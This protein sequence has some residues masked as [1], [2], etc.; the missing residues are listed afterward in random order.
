MG[1]S[2]AA[3]GATGGATE[4]GGDQPGAEPS[5]D[6]AG[7]RRAAPAQRA[8]TSPS[9]S[10]PPSPTDRGSRLPGAWSRSAP[11]SRSTRLPTHRPTPGR[12]RAGA[13]GWRSERPVSGPSPRSARR[14]GFFISEDGFVPDQRRNRRAVRGSRDRHRRCR[15]RGAALPGARGRDRAEPSISPSSRSTSPSRPGQSQARRA[16]LRQRSAA[17]R[18]R[19]ATRRDRSAPSTPERSSCPAGARLLPG[20]GRGA[21]PVQT[22]RRL[23]P[24]ELR[25][26]TRRH[27]RT[28]H[29]HRRP[30]PR[31]RRPRCPHGLLLV[32]AQ[33]LPNPASR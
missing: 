1:P 26:A 8:S 17:G 28:G 27:R 2:G 30:A 24:G 15:D 19:S 4:D 22:S 23:D 16:G 11:I 21:T 31:R 6:R 33:A 7:S 14:S 12:R 20:A 10:R 25:R 32:E 29:R 3:R 9:S 5:C 18:S 13:C